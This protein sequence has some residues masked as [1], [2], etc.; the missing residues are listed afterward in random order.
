MD[1]DLKTI[2]MVIGVAWPVLSA[3]GLYWLSLSFAS[4]ARV[5]ELTKS[6]EDAHRQLGVG[7]QRFVGLEAAIREVKH[8]AKEAEDAANKAEAAAD[9]IHAV[10]VSIATLTGSIGTLAATLEPV[11]RFTFNMVDGHMVIGNRGGDGT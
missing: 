3:A 6:V 9:K 11:K 4:K 8:A 1:L 5:D 7:A 2:L 10:E